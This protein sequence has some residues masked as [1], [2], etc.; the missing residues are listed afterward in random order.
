[1]DLIQKN[2]LSQI[3]DLHEVPEGAYNIRANG[4]SAGVQICNWGK[5][6]LLKAMVYLPSSDFQMPNSSIQNITSGASVV[7]ADVSMWFEGTKIYWSFTN[8]I[9]DGVKKADIDG[10]YDFAQLTEKATFAGP[11]T[12]EIAYNND[13]GKAGA[14]SG[15]ATADAWCMFDVT[16][17]TKTVSTSKA[18]VNLEVVGKNI[19]G[20]NGL[21]DADLEGESAILKAVGGTNEYSA[22]ILNGK[23]SY[24]NV[25]YGKY[26]LTAKEGNY[27]SE[28]EIV[29][30]EATLDKKVRV[31]YQLYVNS[32]PEVSHNKDGDV[33]FKTNSGDMYF[34]TSLYGKVTF[35]EATFTLSKNVSEEKWLAGF[36]ALDSKGQ[37]I[38]VGFRYVPA[39]HRDNTN[40]AESS[41]T[42]QWHSRVNTYWDYKAIK[43]TEGKNSITVRCRVWLVDGSLNMQMFDAETGDELSEIITRADGYTAIVSLRK[44][45]TENVTVTGLVFGNTMPDPTK[46]VEDVPE[47]EPTPDTPSG[48]NDN[49]SDNPQTEQT[50]SCMISANAEVGFIT[51]FAIVGLAFITVKKIKFAKE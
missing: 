48:G 38:T 2:L 23:V 49:P 25:P 7:S 42:S 21:S 18:T 43:G 14:F 27:V 28:E 11:K 3:A 45:T 9:A 6:A 35:A 40:G 46:W 47:E 8:L 19:R 34:N 32:I 41:T 4:V 13:V 29:V 33:A 31:N 37:E 22:V 5:N 15:E 51:V 50:Q 36:T 16:P 10:S 30:S 12:I 26:V 44:S 24:K 17:I 39:G 20:V 1:M